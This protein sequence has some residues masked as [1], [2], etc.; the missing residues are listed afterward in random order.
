M[1]HC[2]GS[3]MLR[4]GIAAILLVVALAVRVSS[5]L[6]SSCNASAPRSDCGAFSSSLR[7]LGLAICLCCRLPRYQPDRVPSEGMLL[8]SDTGIYRRTQPATIYCASLYIHRAGP[9][10]FT[11][12]DR[13]RAEFARRMH[14]ELIAV[15]RIMESSYSSSE[16]DP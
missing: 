11:L 1:P 10:V 5:A 14:R 7:D 3:T 2:H 12:T 9:G 15:G 4:L 8:V 16:Y 13:H 6:G